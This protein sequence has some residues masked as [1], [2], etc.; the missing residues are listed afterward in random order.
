V[1]RL[2]VSAL[3]SITGAFPHPASDPTHPDAGGS[4]LY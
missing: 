1:A 4:T 2:T 3:K